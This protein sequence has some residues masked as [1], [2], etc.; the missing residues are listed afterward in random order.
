MAKKFNELTEAGQKARL[1]KYAKQRAKRGTEEALVRLV[2]PATFKDIKDD[3]RLAVFRF[4]KY[5]K[6][7]KDTEFFTATAFIEKGKDKLEAF[8]ASLEKGQLVSVEYKE[9]NG[10]TNIYNLMDRS[11][12]DKRKK[13]EN[14]PENKQADEP[15]AETAEQME[16]ELEAVHESEPEL[17]I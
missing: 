7:T 12:A 1:E 9:N 11:Y 15:Q 2:R 4:A 14:Q 16:M 10:Y 13:S 6:D 5:D 17:E 3:N 8:Y